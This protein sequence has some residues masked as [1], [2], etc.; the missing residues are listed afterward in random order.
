MAWS[1]V[2]YA[3]TAIRG[4]KLAGRLPARCGEPA[5]DHQRQRDY[6]KGILLRRSTACVIPVTVA[7]SRLHSQRQGPGKRRYRTCE[8]LVRDLSGNA[9]N[10]DLGGLL[11]CVS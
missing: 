4:G 5:A 6:L 8:V 7:K 3:A 10:Q 2:D 11:R 9:T 1:F